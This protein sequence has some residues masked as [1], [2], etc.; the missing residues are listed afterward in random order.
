[1]ELVYVCMYVCICIAMYVPH[2]PDSMCLCKPQM[3]YCSA[4]YYS[5]ETRPLPKACKRCRIPTDLDCIKMWSQCVKKQDEDAHGR[6]SPIIN[7]IIILCYC[8][9]SH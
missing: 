8:S 5:T 2:S 4:A 1:M 6:V 9:I 7:C 3:G